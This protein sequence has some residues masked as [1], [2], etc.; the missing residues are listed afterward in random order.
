M[1]CQI[2]LHESCGMGRCI[3]MMKLI[4]SVIVNATVT[5]YTSAVSGVSLPT[6]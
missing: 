3:V 6:D 4:C 2:S 5:Q 1:R